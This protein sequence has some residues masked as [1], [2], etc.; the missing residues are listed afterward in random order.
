MAAVE[1]AGSRRYRVLGPVEARLDDR[2]LPVAPGQQTLLLAALLARPDQVVPADVLIDAL[3]GE[4]PP[5]GAEGNLRAL[6]S[7]LRRALHGDP[8]LGVDRAGGL[9]E[10]AAAGYRLRLPTTDAGGHPQ[11]L[12]DARGFAASMAQART[13]RRAGQTAAAVEAYR[14]AL[15]LWRGAAFA[16]ATGKDGIGALVA[17]EARRLD[18]ER[19]V[20]DEERLAAELDLG[21]HAELLGELEALATAEPLRER[22][23]ELLMVALHRAGRP[24][25]ALQVY[26]RLRALLAEELGAQPSDAVRA[27]HLRLLRQDPTLVSPSSP[28]PPPRSA[29][30]PRTPSGTAGT[31]TGSDRVRGPAAGTPAVVAAA[32]RLPAGN[33]PV[34]LGRLVGRDAV[35]AQTEEILRSGRRVLTL[36]GTAGVGKTSLALHA[37]ARTAVR[38]AGDDGQRAEACFS[39]GA[40]LVE[41]APVV[42]GYDVVDAVSHALAVQ[43][44]PGLTAIERLVEYL[45]SK[46]LL[47]LLD[48]C[49]HLIDDAAELVDAVAHSCPDVAVLATSRE[50]L[51]VDGEQVCLVPPLT[52]PPPSSIDAARVR[53]AAAAA[54]LV[55]RAQAAAA[56]GFTITDGNAAAVAELCRRLDGVPLA[57]ELAATLMRSFTP[58]EVVE[59]LE[60]RFAL[61]GSG[62]RTATSRH[63]SLKAAIDWSYGLLTGDERHLFDRLSVFAGGFTL[64]AAERVAPVSHGPKGSPNQPAQTLDTVSVAVVLAG[65]VDK[66]MV[67]AT[68]GDASTRYTLL[69]TLRGYGRQ[70]LAARG[71]EQAARRAHATYLTA[72]AQ[73]ASGQL[74][75]PDSPRCAE[76]ITQE[77]DDLRAAHTWALAHDLGLAV[78]LLAALFR[79]VEHRLHPQVPIWAERTIETA[80]KSQVAPA[81]LLPTVYAIAARGAAR[82]GDLDLAKLLAERGAAAGVAPADPARRHPLYA[83]SAVALFQGR[84][85]ESARVAEKVERLSLEAN[86]PWL[87][88]RAHTIRGLAHMYA[89]DLAAATLAA[90]DAQALADRCGDR[91]AIG[92]SRY[93]AGEVLLETDPARAA[94]YLEEALAA[95]RAMDERYLTGVAMV[96][97]TSVRARHGDPKQAASLFSVV[98]DHWQDAGNWTQQWTT[99]RNVV[100]LLVRT[101]SHD[102]AAVLLG[103]IDHRG[104]APPTFGLGADRLHTA[105]NALQQHLNP[106]R[107]AA[108]NSRG[109]AMSDEQVLGVARTALAGLPGHFDPESWRLARDRLERAHHQSAPPTLRTPAPHQ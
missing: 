33:L 73:R 103:A 31:S 91:A 58:G 44:R 34:T 35:L 24:R 56:P 8:P 19:A 7:K 54:L 99:I 23:T 29:R 64:K 32:E 75:T 86:D 45:R 14:A 70:R 104:T 53:R 68:T 89:G 10:F 3:W 39:D 5:P 85:Q 55:A 105:R 61:L 6:V 46:R 96:S 43:Q 106:H 108:M 13:A 9:L 51:G 17:R 88:V 4:V 25:E 83:L 76:A 107:L 28:P 30:A 69:E 84:L 77:L 87:A 37:A 36:T 22:P 71:E 47:L 62:P 79:Y 21:R 26:R 48:N 94:A 67:V 49:E 60:H 74:A 40:W 80:E 18:A 63:R 109:A 15:G 27:L 66:S 101:D 72:F 95:A 90:D 92:W 11:E 100:E 41:L 38:A 1:T 102:D 50:P 82:R 78:R 42:D 2:V 65:L 16:G 97:A 59:L 12:L 52:V 20:G 81:R 98:I 57:I 93:L